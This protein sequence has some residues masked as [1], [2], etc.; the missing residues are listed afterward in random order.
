MRKPSALIIVCSVLASCLVTPA[1]ADAAPLYPDLKTLSPR[2]LRFDRADVSQDGSGVMHNVLRFTNTVWNAGQGKLEMRSTINPTTKQGPAVQ[3]IYDD[4]GGFADTTIGNF[5]YHLE[6]AHYHYDDWGRYQLWNAAEYDAWVASGRTQGAPEDIGTKT[7]SCVLDE[8]FIRGL[9]GTPY[10]AVFPWEGCSPN[11]Q[12]LMVQGLS[13][14]WGDTYD[15]W[16]FEQW[17]DLDQGK[18]ADGDYVLRSVTDP[19]NKVIE[20]AGKAD[21]SREGVVVNEGVTRFKVQGG[22]IVDSNPPEGSVRIND[23]AAKT[24][25][26]DVSV[27][28][29]GRDDV[30]GVTHVRLSNDGTT[31]TATRTYTGSGSA[32][33]STAWNLTD[34]AYGGTSTDGTKTVYVQFRDATGKW[35]AAETDTIVLDRGGS[36][37]GTTPYSKAVMA[38]GPAGYWRLGETSGTTAA[39]LTGGQTGTYL[40]SPQLGVTG[41]LSGETNSA[42]RLDGVD[43]YVRV[44]STSALNPT[45]AVSVE[46][47]I[48]PE[49]IPTVGA[50]ATVATKPEAYSIQFNGPRLE[51][52]VM[53]FGTRYRTQ[54]PVGAVQVGSTYHVVGTYDGATARLYLNGEQ[55]ASR[56]LTG[57]IGSNGNSLNLGSWSGWNE[58]FKGT[59]DEVA[60]YGSAL[61]ASRVTAHYDAAGSTPPPPDPTVATPND[62]KATAVSP[63]QVDL[64]WVDNSSNE[65]EFVV[66]WDTASQFTSP[67]SATVPGDTTQRSVT[68]LSPSTQYYFRVRARNATTTSNWSG[69]ATATTPSLPPPPPPPPPPP[70]SYS[71]TVLEDAPVSYWRLGD[72]GTTA[73]D[74]QGVNN[75][76]YFNAPTL[77]ATSLL[78]S[79]TTDE[80]VAFDGAND[81]V[82]VANSAS[83]G[84]SSQLSLEAWIRPTSLPAS[85]AFRSVVTKPEAYSLQFNGGRL[86]F[87]IMQF[88][89]RQRLQAPLGTI[90]PGSTYHVVGT[91]DGATRRLYVNGSQVA[92]A[93]L[94]G[95]ATLGSHGLFVG[96]WNGWSEFF[97][98]TIDEVAVYG[99]ALSAAR[100]AA[101]RA[102]GQ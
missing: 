43:D 18:L 64:Q 101:H 26:A 93:P 58:R 7:T 86:E 63:S 8:E 92:S 67:Q 81:Q 59:V 21:Q 74:T 66:E 36:T 28:V 84:L 34:A 94:N 12:N 16:R 52:T 38:D 37:G 42:V 13:V 45:A 9:T 80:A 41:L 22:A 77:G 99:S 39:N 49:A 44:P 10:P 90:Q 68:G 54:A 53:R 15:Y 56:A 61:A 57:P 51:F 46:A 100:V 79:D 96:S 88:G 76:T 75:G 35:S 78:D 3:R 25:S 72:A 85:G 48:K 87:T 97:A 1:A 89:V 102:A 83:L 2:D 70:S 17:I 40:N 33:M 69:P 50:F 32:A 5:Y 98:G 60:V 73:A 65:T 71:T 24:S 6:H 62:L 19:L 30:S 91:F 14:G 82:R 55:V 11:S 27:K 20:S 23:I 47:W 31:W 29:L 95:G 4:A